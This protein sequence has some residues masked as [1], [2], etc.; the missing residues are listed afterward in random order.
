MVKRLN[1]I[2]R[3]IYVGMDV[4]WHKNFATCDT[5]KLRFT[6]VSYPMV[7][8]KVRIR[9]IVIVRVQVTENSYGS[10]YGHKYG[11]Y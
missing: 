7:A 1:F 11:R 8:V 4:I 5:G 10:G 2:W 3:V 9:V 6:T